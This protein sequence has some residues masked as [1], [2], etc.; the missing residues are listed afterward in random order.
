MGVAVGGRATNTIDARAGETGIADPRQRLAIEVSGSPPPDRSIRLAVSGRC[1]QPSHPP[2][3]AGIHSCQQQ[4]GFGRIQ[5]RE[6]IGGVVGIHLQHVGCPGG[7][8]ATTPA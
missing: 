5:D 2:G 8:A 3:V 7:P 6:Q 4:L 1:Q